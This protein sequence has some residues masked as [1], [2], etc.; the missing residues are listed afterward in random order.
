M[1]KV[2]INS[3]LA[4]LV[5]AASFN[6]SAS[7]ITHEFNN[8]D[9]LANW[10]VDRAAPAGFEI[11]NNELVMTVAGPADIDD[12]FNTQGMYLDIGESTF[13]SIDMYID[14][15][16]SQPES[17]GGFWATAFDDTD[18]ISAYPIL[19]FQGYA[20]GDIA[21]YD[22]DSG[23]PDAGWGA[24]STLFNWDA[25]NTLA[26]EITNAGVEYSLNGVTVHTNS[27]SNIEYFGEVILNGFYEESDF[28]V[29][30]DNLTYGSV[31]VPEPA[32]LAIFALGLMGLA[33]RR[34]KK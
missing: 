22:I 20:G 4:G 11:I 7:L 1:S 25:F 17:Y 28:T 27:V 16:W 13:M 34:F 31:D 19:E 6:S 29:R 21:S 8:G 32:T 30:Y 33:S 14:S 12:F 10:G 18:T 26:F 24:Y 2:I 23:L 9:S 3:L 15:S 5:L